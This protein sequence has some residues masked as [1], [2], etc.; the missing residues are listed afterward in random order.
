MGT[1]ILFDKII[2]SKPRKIDNTYIC[3]IYYNVKNENLQFT[4]T[5]VNIISVKPL[6]NR[7]EFFLDFKNKNYYNFLFDFNTFITNIVKEKTTR[8][9]N[10]NMNID[11]IDDY[12]TNPL[13]YDKN[14]GDIIRL[15]CIGKEKNIREQIGKKINIHIQFNQLK[16][17][18]QKFLLECEIINYQEANTN[19]DIIDEDTDNSSDET[20]EPTADDIDVIKNKYI[21][22]TDNYLNNLKTMISSFELK[23]NNIESIKINLLNT[24]NVQNIINIC[25]DLEKLCE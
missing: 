1:D 23:I 2:I 19:C 22:S 6:K 20:P 17:Y 8:W 15:K 9:F 16:F 4:F 11:L 14:N 7:N 13:L 21:K 24:K 3:P 18:K 5:N 12:Y 25:N 10:N